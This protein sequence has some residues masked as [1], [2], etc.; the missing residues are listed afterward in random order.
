[1]NAYLFGKLKRITFRP[2]LLSLIALLSGCATNTVYLH[3]YEIEQE[4]IDKIVASLKE[5]EFEVEVSDRIPPIL[6]FGNF[7][8][9]PRDPG[10]N[11]PLVKILDAIGEHGYNTNLIAQSRVRNHYYTKKTNIG[12]YLINP[13]VE[14]LSAQQ[15]LETEFAFNLTDV[16]FSSTN[17]ISLF[18]LEFGK[19]NTAIIRQTTPKSNDKWTFQWQQAEDTITIIVDDKTINYTLEKDY[20]RSGNRSDLL[21]TFFPGNAL[22]LG[23]SEPFACKYESTIHL[24][25]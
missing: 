6:K 18:S 11:E 5:K 12:L 14:L 1:M 15:Q 4:E 19:D 7:I 22:A 17:C 2:L 10:D 9:Y 8:I 3:T 20:K 23:I 25:D 24:V 16:I 13:R 21:L